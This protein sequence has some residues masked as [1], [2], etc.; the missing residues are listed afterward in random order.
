MSYVSRTDLY[1]FLF[2]W[3]SLS[4]PFLASSWLLPHHHQVYF[5]FSVL[6]TGRFLQSFCIVAVLGAGKE[7]AHLG[8]PQ[9]VRVH[10]ATSVSLF[11]FM[12]QSQLI[13]HSLL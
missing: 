9:E 11:M 12:H 3:R 2:D 5:L 1:Q 8:D 13:T 4:L 10:G 6:L 7:A